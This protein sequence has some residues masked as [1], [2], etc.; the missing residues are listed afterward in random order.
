MR[1]TCIIPSTCTGMVLTYLRKCIDSLRKSSELSKV[2]LR[3]LVVVDSSSVKNPFKSEIDLFLYA[4]EKP[5]FA[6][7]NN[8]G[9]EEA[10]KTFPPDY[11]LL[12]N[13][14][15]WVENNFFTRLIKI[16]K[17]SKPEL[18]CPLVYKGTSSKI[19]SF[20]TEYFRSGYAKSAEEL[21]IETTLAP[22][23]CLLVKASFLRRVKNVYGFYFNPIFHSYYE[24]TE[25]SIRTLMIGGV[26]KKDVKLVARHFGSLSFGKHSS[27][28]IYYSLRNLVWVIILTWPSRFIFRHFLK[29]AFIQAL[30][31]LEFFQIYLRIFVDTL[32]NLKQL[33]VIRGQIVP[34]YSKDIDFGT[35]L[36]RYTFRT[37]RLGILI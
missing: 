8:I 37:R 5:G 30:F 15:A 12:I 22:A 9:I 6:Q 23:A 10:L 4:G 27:K 11:I 21:N 1:V 3:V 32:K 24:D 16:L 35:L 7:M 20:G 28:V 34:K 29:I 25:F 31:F 33:L 18:I 19:D 14:D 17:Y 26:I 13:D 2:E 36:S